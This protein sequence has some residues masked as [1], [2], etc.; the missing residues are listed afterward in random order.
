MKKNVILDLISR[1]LT[2]FMILFGLYLLLYGHVSPGG[3]FQGGVV[4]ASGII[5]LSVSR[6]VTTVERL[7][8]YSSLSIV[9]AI[10]FF[11]L[12]AAGLA[13]MAAGA[14]FL[15]NPL[16]H[17]ETVAAPRFSMILILNILIGLK[18]GAGVSLICIR[19]F[20]EE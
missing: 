17:V 14:G 10:C 12:I 20:R 1:K 11:L 7:F 15:G 13:G 6:G 2:P 4:I 18:V 9:E 3:G 8:P 16:R 19:I 5:L